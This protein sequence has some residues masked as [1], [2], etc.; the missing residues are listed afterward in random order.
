MLLSEMI[1]E[2]RDANGCSL[3]E[4]R[5]HV[6]RKH[7]CEKLRGCKNTYELSEWLIKILR[8]EFVNGYK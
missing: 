1:E 6:C 8:F 7:F 3:P 5:Q 4:A 2:F